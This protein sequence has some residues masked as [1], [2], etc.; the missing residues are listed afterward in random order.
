MNEDKR[1]RE[2]ELN[3]AFLKID[4][5]VSKPGLK[6]ET[7]HTHSSR[8]CINWLTKAVSNLQ[9]ANVPALSRPSHTCS[10]I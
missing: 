1:R 10:M 2:E 6:N 7:K 9:Q 3:M 8:V 4:V 5:L